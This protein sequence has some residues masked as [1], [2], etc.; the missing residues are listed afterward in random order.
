MLSTENRAGLLQCIS[1]GQRPCTLQ[2]VIEGL[3]EC[4]QERS[5]TRRF[6][7]DLVSHNPNVLPP[8]EG[9]EVGHLLQ[10]TDCYH[11]DVACFQEPAIKL[12]TLT[13]QSQTWQEL[14]TFIWEQLWSAF[15]ISLVMFRIQ[16]GVNEAG[17]H[18]QF[19]NFQFKT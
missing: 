17:I 9:L 3:L 16:V 5:L 14:P 15:T 2:S 18:I 12:K 6:R 8:S 11:S 4:L 1:C 13:S 10:P 7:E 19:C